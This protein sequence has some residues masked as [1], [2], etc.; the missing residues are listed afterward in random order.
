MYKVQTLK[1]SFYEGDSFTQ[2]IAENVDYKTATIDGK[3]TFHGMGI[4]SATTGQFGVERV[5]TPHTMPETNEGRTCYKKQRSTCST[6][7]QLSSPW[8]TWNYF[9]TT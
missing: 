8:Y 5:G 9:K 1:I 7:Y 6:V 2:W 3:Q 4:I